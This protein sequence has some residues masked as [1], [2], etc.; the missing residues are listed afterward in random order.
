MPS[1]GLQDLMKRLTILWAA[2]IAFPMAVAASL[3]LMVDRSRISPLPDAVFWAL[4]ALAI[5]ELPLAFVIPNAMLRQGSMPATTRL[6]SV[7]AVR[8]ALLESSVLLP[9]IGYALSGRALALA[10]AALPF[11]LLLAQKPS[12]D[13]VRLRLRS[14]E[15]P[16]AP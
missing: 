1:D 2:Q 13:D 8:G 10:F 11:A 7:F 15:A 14:I 4:L 6:T 5:V 16:R 12:L 9:V 3:L